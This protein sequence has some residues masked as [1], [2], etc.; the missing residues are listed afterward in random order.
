[1]SSMKSKCFLDSNVLIYFLDRKSSYHKKAVGII[2]KLDPDTYTLLISPLVIDE[3]LYAMKR[4]MLHEGIPPSRNF[5]ELGRA[6]DTIIALK[7]IEIVTVSTDKSVNRKV[8]NIM[9]QFKLQPRDAYHLL[10]MQENGIDEFATF[11]S[12]FKRVFAKKILKHRK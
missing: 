12:D 10:T 6:Y 7:N 3:L 1:M 9:E 4:I 8:I 5:Q 11:D 2:T